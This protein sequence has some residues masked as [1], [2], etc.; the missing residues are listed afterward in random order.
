LKSSHEAA[1]GALLVRDLAQ[2]IGDVWGFPLPPLLLE[3]L[4]HEIDLAQR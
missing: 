3:A 2:V 1:Q 4:G